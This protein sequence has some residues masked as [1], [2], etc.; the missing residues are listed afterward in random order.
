MDFIKLVV[1]I[2]ASTATSLAALMSITLFLRVHWPAPI[3]WILKLYVSALSPLFFLI[4]VV[5]T[6]A[7]QTT[8]STFISIIGIYVSVI[9]LIHIFR[10]TGPPNSSVGFEHA[11]GSFWEGPINSQQK[12]FFLPRRMTLRLPAVP[13]PS[14]EQNI[15]FAI[16]PETGRKLLCDVWQ[17]HS[18]ITPSGLAFIYLHGAA[19]YMLDKDL[20]TRS[21]F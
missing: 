20:G 7:G 13:N 19:W 17:P 16:I 15:S 3:L 4:G 6:I 10:V 12:R 18:T 5:G 2:L 21:F 9:F 14:L 1:Q 11:F 8:G